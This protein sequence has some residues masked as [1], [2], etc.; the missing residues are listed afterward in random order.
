[1]SVMNSFRNEV[2]D[3]VRDAL[4]K[5][6]VNERFEIEIPSADNADLAV[7]CFLLAKAMKR[8]P[9]EIASA[10]AKDIV[11]KGTISKVQALNGYLNFTMDRNALMNGTIAEILEKGDEYGRLPPK[12]R[13]VNLEHTSTNP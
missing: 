9:A 13:K 3:S 11:P 10:L 4:S 7:P 12:G 2:S 6:G 8:P 1:M 5:M